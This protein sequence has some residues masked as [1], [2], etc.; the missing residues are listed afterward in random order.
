MALTT[1]QADIPIHI[2]VSLPLTPMSSMHF[3]LARTITSL[4]KFSFALPLYL[5]LHMVVTYCHLWLYTA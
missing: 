5:I 1:H 2:Q 4:Q 3:F